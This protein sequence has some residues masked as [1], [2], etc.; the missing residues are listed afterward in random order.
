MTDKRIKMDCPFCGTPK[1]RIQVK[2]IR[3]GAL[4][5]LFCPTCGC[6]FTGQSK[7]E[8]ISKWNCR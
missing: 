1:E 8:V 4:V 6:E 2:V 3:T 5:R 7:T